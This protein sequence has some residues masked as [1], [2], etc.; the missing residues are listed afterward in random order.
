MGKQSFLDD[1][2]INTDLARRLIVGFLR[3]EIDKAGFSRAVLGVS[4]GIDSALAC[5]LA[6]EALG[7][8]NILAL[9]LP[10][11]TSSPDSLFHAQLVIDQLGVRA[12][13]IE[14]TP[15]VNPF[16]ERFPDMPSMRKGNVMA[17]TR[18]IVLY[19]QSAAFDGL[20]VGS[21][22]KTEALLGYTT[23]HGDSAAAMH[24]LADLYKAQV[25]QLARALGV[26]DV[27][28]D[29]PPSADLWPG[30]TD[31]GELGFTY[32][33]ADQLLYLLIDR[34]HSPDEAVEAGFERS[35]VESVWGQVQRTHYKRRLP[36]VPKL[37]TR[38]EEGMS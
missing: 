8:E 16:F 33:E 30:Q 24:P 27:V 21:A 26:P 1:L 20:V 3:E 36:L 2:H 7:P 31:E 29:K 23:L 32:D 25:R 12:D 9:R 11:S 10:Y 19:D 18:M 14:I 5:F 28:V 6:A 13:T 22:N 38:S 37:S 17:R 34:H 4:G 15:M 35:L